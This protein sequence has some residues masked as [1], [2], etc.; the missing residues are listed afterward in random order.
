MMS[1]HKFRNVSC[2]FYH[3]VAIDADG[4]LWAFGSNPYGQVGILK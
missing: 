3:T 2:G 4:L 1:D